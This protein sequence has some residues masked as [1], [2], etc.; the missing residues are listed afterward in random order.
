MNKLLVRTTSILILA[1]VMIVGMSAC[2]GL[3]LSQTI[4]ANTKAIEASA[5]QVDRVEVYPI[6]YS[7]NPAHIQAGVEVV[8]ND[9][10]GQLIQVYQQANPSVVLIINGEASGS[11]FVYDSEGRIVTNN[12]VISGGR[13]YE[14]IFA[15]GERSS[16][17]LVGAD[18]DSDLAVIQVEQIP[19]GVE[20]LPLSVDDVQ[21]GQFVV[22][23]G[24][25]FGEQGS[26][27]LGI[28]SGLGRSLPSQRQAA[29][30]SYYTLPEVIQT[31][32][33]IN[34]GNSGGPL[35][36]L[37]GEVVG[38]NSAIASLT[39]SNTGVGFSIPVKAVRLIVPGLIKSGQYNYPYMGVSFDGEI[40][41]SEQQVYGLE[42]VEGIYILSIAPGSPAEKAGLKAADLNT[43]KGG[44]L[45]VA[46]D[47]DPVASFA[48]LNSYLIFEA[49]IGQL[50]ELTVIRNGQRMVVPLT[51]TE[52]P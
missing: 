41:L 20:S 29:G 7:D 24:N 51:L 52:R 15:N 32:A 6:S 11:G 46:I 25:P 45:V 1:I 33:P 47:G 5:S 2:S 9:L 48:D 16:A 40:T 14:V 4:P 27:S 31:D 13:T 21:V 3:T 37:S 39:G 22:A 30:G 17:T 34:P 44:D 23:I 10:Q 42:Q 12:H 35:L 49:R 19:E 36:N 50:I 26:M 43:G 28:V 38:V 18:A 8:Q